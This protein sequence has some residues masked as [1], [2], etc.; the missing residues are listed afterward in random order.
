[1]GQP[2]FDRDEHQQQGR[3]KWYMNVCWTLETKMC[4]LTHVFYYTDYTMICISV[5]LT[6]EWRLVFL[7]LTLIG[8]SWVARTIICKWS[9]GSQEVLKDLK[10]KKNSSFNLFKG[11]F[12][13]CKYTVIIYPFWKKSLYKLLITS[14]HASLRNW[15]VVDK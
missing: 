14:F 7:V 9:R 8:L 2:K 10:I 3:C 5:S 15:E 11:T 13:T 1:M 6:I 4:Y 12:E